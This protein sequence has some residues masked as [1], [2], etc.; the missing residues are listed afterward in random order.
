MDRKNR[1][2]SI[3]KTRTQPDIFDENEEQTLGG[4]GKERRVS[5][6]NVKHVKN[7]DKE[8][9]NF[10]HASPLREKI[11][12][13]MDSDGILTPRGR[14]LAEDETI[15]VFQENNTTRRETVDMSIVAE[16]DNTM[17]IFE[18][19][20]ERTISRSVQNSNPNPN[21]TLDMSIDKSM[22]PG[23]EDTMMIFNLPAEASKQPVPNPNKTLDMSIDPTPTG[24]DTMMIFNIPKLSEAPKMSK[25][26]TVADDTMAIFNMTDREEMDMELEGFEQKMEQKSTE[27][28]SNSEDILM[29]QTMDITE[30]KEAE[31]SSVKPEILNDTMAIFNGILER[32]LAEN[33][34]E[35]AERSE[36]SMD[37]SAQVTAEIPS[38]TAQFSAEKE[39]GGGEFVPEIS[40]EMDIETLILEVN[41]G[42]GEGSFVELERDDTLRESTIQAENAEKEQDEAENIRAMMIEPTNLSVLNLK[43][44]DDVGFLLEKEKTVEME[45][46]QEEATTFSQSFKSC[47]MELENQSITNRSINQSINNRREEIQEIQETTL[48]SGNKSLTEILCGQEPKI[49]KEM[50]RRR[51][52]IQNET[53]IL[54]AGGNRT[55][56]SLT[57]V[58]S[59]FVANSSINGAGTGTGGIRKDIFYLNTSIRSSPNV[60]SPSSPITKLP[61]FDQAVSKIVWLENSK[62]ATEMNQ[63]AGE[64]LAEIRESIEKEAAKLDKSKI[65]GIEKGN[66]KKFTL[67][68]KDVIRDARIVAEIDLLKMR[69]KFAAQKKAE[70]HREN[71]KMSGEIEENE[72]NLEIF[73]TLGEEN[74]RLDELEKMTTNAMPIHK[75]KTEII[76]LRVLKS[77]KDWE[78]QR[79]KAKKVKE[80]EKIIEEKRKMIEELKKL[81]EK[82]QMEKEEKRMKL[83]IEIDEIMRDA[84]K[85]N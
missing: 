63:L 60:N 72:R 7:Y 79:E 28:P 76:R 84:P 40:D 50:R 41:N 71:E 8:R 24:E 81:L 52:S 37:I 19:E 31:K 54:S 27:I 48:I 64:K 69:L 3:L 13:T 46:E 65:E 10:L 70:M 18:L 22:N 4:A 67:D 30:S 9:G 34:A 68:E 35:I 12:D 80:F 26:I 44:S 57:C 20:V 1:R 36:D 11:T 74:E 53:S 23:G 25:T 32:N 16:T 59:S 62:F 17:A 5:F 77:K 39:D 21:Q 78:K 2:S 6:H 14:Q 51:E 15:Q 56:R 82:K 61:I 83:Q 43:Q 42:G 66:M 49:L 47:V 75:L 85:T 73:G 45:Q 55:R 33:R 29:S 38:E 58:N